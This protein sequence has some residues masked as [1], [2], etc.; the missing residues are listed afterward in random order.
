MGHLGRRCRRHVCRIPEVLQDFAQ[1]CPRAGESFVHP[2]YAPSRFSV[3]RFRLNLYT[4]TWDA[5]GHLS[6][7]QNAEAGELENHYLNTYGSV[8]RWKA[9][10][11]VREFLYQ[12][13]RDW[14]L[15]RLR[16]GQEDRLWMADPKAISHILNSGDLWVKTVATR[17]IT[18]ILFDRGVAWA[19]GDVHKRQRKALAPAFGH[20][21]SKALMPRFL[22]VA[23][24]VCEDYQRPPTLP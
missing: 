4:G 8:V 21:E 22:L 19:E 12:F 17:E 3:F 9:P 23:N 10:L 6:S 1:R 13:L 15:D 18:A 5:V 7:L 24:K 2:W 16:S 11:G 14:G 20:S